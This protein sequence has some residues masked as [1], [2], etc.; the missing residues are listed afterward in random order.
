MAAEMVQD[1][2]APTPIMRSPRRQPV[3]AA[4]VRPALVPLSPQQAEIWRESARSAQVRVLRLAGEVDV[5]ALDRALA[6]VS[7]R[8]EALRTV[9][10]VR[11]GVPV[12]R[13]LDGFVPGLLGIECARHHDPVDLARTALSVPGAVPFQ[14]VLVRV[15]A[16]EHVLVVGADSLSVDEWSWHVILRDLACAYRAESGAGNGPGSVAEVG[17]VDAALWQEKQRASGAWQAMADYWRDRLAGIPDRLAFPAT[18]LSKGSAQWL[19]RRLPQAT[20]A[21]L[22]ALGRRLGVPQWITMLVPY[23]YA[24]GSALDSPA[25]A[26]GVPAMGVRTVPGLDAT[27]GRLTGMLPLPFA[28]LGDLSAAEAMRATHRTARQDYAH[29]ELPYELMM[30]SGARRIPAAFS[31]RYPPEAPPDFGG[32]A[33][34][35]EEAADPPSPFDLWLRLS[36]GPQS[37]RLRWCY[38]PG[39][40]SP[41]QVECI[42]DAYERLLA[43]AVDAPDRALSGLTRT[44]RPAVRDGLIRVAPVSRGLDGPLVVM[45]PPIG[46]GIMNYAGLARALPGDVSLVSFELAGSAETSVTAIAAEALA[47]LPARARQPGTVFGGWSAGGVVAQEMARQAVATSRILAPVVAIDSEPFAGPAPGSRTLLANFVADLGLPESWPG[48]DIAGDETSLL[49]R[50]LE[51][52]RSAGL[53]RGVQLADL[54]GRYRLFCRNFRAYARHQPA[55]H[56][57]TLHLLAASHD[58]ASGAWRPLADRLYVHLLSGDHYSIMRPPAVHAV[59]DVIA[60]VAYDHWR[61]PNPKVSG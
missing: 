49:G 16:A 32:V 48:H 46:G 29:M 4:A 18:G 8:H 24:V 15:T 61:A 17:S 37:V 27:V 7:G 14:A 39:G 20:A 19:V 36:A 9:I 22:E 54:E 21:G 12:Q 41:V 43:A 6:L 45:A 42:A 56:A 55:Y 1:R 28:G 10:Q 53:A 25:L 47:A 50:A 23:A 38:D 52:L 11:D 35:L 5:L 44:R 2:P 26:I 59:A 57:G 30:E 34:A 51:A 31:L 33:S 40:V 60:T 3:T 13:L 58:R